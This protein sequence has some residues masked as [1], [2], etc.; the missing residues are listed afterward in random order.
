[1]KKIRIKPLKLLH[2]WVQKQQKAATIRKQ[3]RDGQGRLPPGARNSLLT[4]NFS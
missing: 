1:M 3:P 4:R 2:S